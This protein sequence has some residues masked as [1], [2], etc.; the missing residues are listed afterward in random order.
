MVRQLRE[1]STSSRSL[2]SS[3]L[4]TVH[5]LLSARVQGRQ[6]S[7]TDHVMKFNADEEV[8]GWH[9]VPKVPLFTVGQSLQPHEDRT[10]PIDLIFTMEVLL[11]VVQLNANSS[12]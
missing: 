7:F 1:Q 11:V 8:C 4:V 6:R 10:V 2:Q 3:M 9:G 12:S 5:M